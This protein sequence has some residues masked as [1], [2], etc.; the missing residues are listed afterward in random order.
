ILFFLLIPIIGMSQVQIGQPIDWKEKRSSGLIYYSQFSFS[1][2]GTVVAI[3]NE[4]E[5]YNGINSGQVEVYKNVAGKWTQI[6]QSLYGESPNDFFG[7]SVSLSADGNILAIGALNTNVN[8]DNSGRV[9]VYKNA[10]SGWIQVGQ[11]ID[12]EDHGGQFGYCVS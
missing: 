10:S 1:S 8:G 7:S 11:S 3:G 4:D 2:D 9:R 12:G 5:E 6:G